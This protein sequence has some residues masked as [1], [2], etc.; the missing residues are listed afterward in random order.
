MR[1]TFFW[2]VV[3]VLV[4]TAANARADWLRHEETGEYSVT[5]DI[6]SIAYESSNADYVYS[7]TNGEVEITLYK[8]PGGVVFIP[9]SID[10]IPV[11]SVGS[12]AFLTNPHV[13]NYVTNITIPDS[14]R[15]IKTH[16]FAFGDLLSSVSLGNGLITVGDNAFENCA[17]TDVIIPDSV[18]SIGKSAFEACMWLTT[19]TLGDGVVAIGDNA[20][21]SCMALN[22]VVIGDSVA[23]IGDFAF[24]N[25]GLTSIIIP[26]STLSIGDYAFAA[27][28]LLT[29]YFLGN[30]PLMGTAVFTDFRF[31][32]TVCYTL[33]ALGFTTPIWEVYPAEPCADGPPAIGVGPFV[34]AGW[35]PLLSSAPQSPTYMGQN[36]FILWTFS[37]DFA[38]CSEDCTHTAKYQVAGD[39]QW[40]A[41]S[42]SSDAAN[43]YAWVELPVTSLQ[44]ATTYAFRFAVTDCASQTTGSDTHYFRV[45]VTDAPP[46]ITGGPWLAAGSWPLLP[47]SASRAFMLSQDYD[48]LWAF[49]DD[50][51]S[52]A[53]LC[54]QRA[55]YRKV[56]DT[57]WTGMEEYTDPT[58][59]AY[60]Y[61][62]LPVASLENGTY[63]FRVEFLDCAGQKSSTGK[64]FYFTVDR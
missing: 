33:G 53:G 28:N 58:G 7:V 34:A 52:C 45:A 37:D 41:L 46:A 26:A 11:V 2:L 62:T 18:T 22:S 50:Y 35:W 24:Y 47:T 64:L 54:T 30:A 43:G 10:G 57:A 4:F 21:D 12:A 14:V 29:A 19:V 9:G 27:T 60:A 36:Y 51:A 23:N 59:R 40:T 17:L 63:Q 55:R 5:S 1:N 15:I 61:T 42:V 48:V 3:C 39:S 49:S 56:G 38:F 31:N 8:G 32:F 13:C 44:N 6:A 25:T 16:A 20:F